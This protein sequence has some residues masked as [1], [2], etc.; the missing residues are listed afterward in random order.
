ME[1]DK[2]LLLNTE[3]E[4]PIFQIFI[5][6]KG[7]KEKCIIFFIKQKTHITEDNKE[8]NAEDSGDLFISTMITLLLSFNVLNI[9]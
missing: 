8:S 3:N 2:I 7:K 1:Y 9:T 4:A 5:K 6:I